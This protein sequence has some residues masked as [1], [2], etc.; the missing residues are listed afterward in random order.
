[1][2]AFKHIVPILL[3]AILLP[4]VSPTALSAVPSN[5]T[6]VV[7]AD[8]EAAKARDYLLSQYKNGA[9]DW[10]LIALSAQTGNKD[11]QRIADLKKN[12]MNKTISQ[13][14]SK[15]D[16]PRVTTD[17]AR[18]ALAVA[19]A[20][21]NPRNC[22]GID[23]VQNLIDS[24]TPSGKFADL[25]DGTGEE[26]VN[27]HI[28]AIIVLYSCGE[29]VPQPEMA[30]RWLIDH[31]NRDGGFGFKASSNVSDVDITAQ[32]LLALN[33]L[34]DTSSSPVVRRGLAY[35]K[36]RQ[37]ASAGFAGWGGE[38]CESSASVLQTLIAFRIDPLA[39]QWTVKSKNMLGFMKSCQLDNGA[40]G[41][42]AGGTA[43]VMATEHA[44]LALSEYRDGVTIYQKLHKS[45]LQKSSKPRVKG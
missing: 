20:N 27:A 16:L 15:S 26:L 31:Q 39:A 13:L 42:L 36:K 5:K 44:L 2:R 30:R 33:C 23:L 37:A 3:I 9:S 24:Q 34:G 7:E 40:F 1:M 14:K 28:W 41:H 21:G 12:W 19:A 17:Y 43:N 32:A 25:V 10:G 38:N 29:E 8:K 22:G 6:A 11:S 35:L 18:L 45:R 4:I